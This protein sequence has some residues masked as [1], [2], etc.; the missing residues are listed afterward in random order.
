MTFIFCVLC[1]LAFGFSRFMQRRE[2]NSLM[3][4]I[5]LYVIG[6]FGCVFN[7]IMAVCCLVG[8]TPYDLDVHGFMVSFFLLT[9]FAIQ[10]DEIKGRPFRKTV[11]F[12]L[13]VLFKHWE[14]YQIV[15]GKWIC[16]IGSIIML[17]T[18]IKFFYKQL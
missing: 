7:A 11:K 1:Y 5:G 18:E 13:S 12:S 10:I 14:Y 16:I 4:R 8:F 15:V 6:Y 2:S 17:Y 9:L 3:E